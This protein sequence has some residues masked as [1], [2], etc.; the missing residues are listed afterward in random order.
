MALADV[1]FLSAGLSCHS[2]SSHCFPVNRLDSFLL[3]HLT[4][5]SRSASRA[6]VFWVGGPYCKG[7]VW[8]KC[9]IMLAFLGRRTEPVVECE[10]RRC[11]GWSFLSLCI[12]GGGGG[13]GVFT[14]TVLITVAN[15]L[16]NP[17]P[18]LKCLIN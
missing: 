6:R 17:G 13:S 10:S 3:C 18:T 5:N 15:C 12:I 9:S 2:D 14:S 7:S 11:L 4:F 16:H 8:T 1:P